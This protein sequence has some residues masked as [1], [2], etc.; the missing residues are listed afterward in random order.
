MKVN[1][2]KQDGSTVTTEV[3]TGTNMMEAAITG[4][5]TGVLGECGGNLSCATCHV[6]VDPAWVDNHM[7]RSAISRMQCLMRPR[8]SAPRPTA[9]HVRSLQTM[10]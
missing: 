10:R 2:T 1:W 9:C 6:V 8:Q 4:N 3:A 5:I 7:A